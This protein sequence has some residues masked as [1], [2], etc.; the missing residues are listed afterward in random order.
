MWLPC[1]NVTGG[2]KFGYLA[3]MLHGAVRVVTMQECYMGRYVWL[4]CRNVTGGGKCGY[5]AGMLQEAV[6]AVTM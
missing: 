2:G 4:P 6:S 5:H 3:V 1:R